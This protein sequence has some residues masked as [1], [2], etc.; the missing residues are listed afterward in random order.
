MDRLADV[1]E[2]LYSNSIAIIHDGTHSMDRLL[3]DSRIDLTQ[4]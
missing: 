3:E 2:F 4:R 1:S